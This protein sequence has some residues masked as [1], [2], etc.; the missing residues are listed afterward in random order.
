MRDRFRDD[1]QR[2]AVKLIEK[3]GNEQENKDVDAVQASL[4]KELERGESHVEVRGSKSRAS[5]SSLILTAAV[6]LSTET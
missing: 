4:A 6:S 1:R 3:V 2:V 5:C